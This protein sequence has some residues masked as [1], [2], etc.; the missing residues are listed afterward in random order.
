K[1]TS[2]RTFSGLT[3]TFIRVC[4]SVDEADPQD[5]VDPNA[6]LVSH[7]PRAETLVSTGP[8]KVDNVHGTKSRPEADWGNVFCM[9]RELLL[10][11]GGVSK[12]C[13]RKSTVHPE[14]FFIYQ[15]LWFTPLQ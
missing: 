6:L 9:S 7:G 15:Y 10:Y 13:P 12:L 14:H 5:C 2:K 3:L 8:G 1:T 11:R 4:G